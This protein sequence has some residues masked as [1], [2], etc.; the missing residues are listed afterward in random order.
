MNS[1]SLQLARFS[2]A[3]TTLF[4]RVDKLPVG[5]LAKSAAGVFCSAHPGPRPCGPAER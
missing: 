5:A 3:K 4:A 2:R 1:R